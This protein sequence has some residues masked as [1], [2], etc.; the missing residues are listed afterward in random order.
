M[1]RRAAVALVLSGTVSA[2]SVLPASA[3]D[4]RCSAAPLDG[5]IYLR[6]GMN[7]WIPA[8]EYAFTWD[9][10]SYVLSV[11]LQGMQDFKIADG[12]WTPARSFGG[13]A[14]MP[15][16][17][18]DVLI[19]VRAAADGGA[20]NLSYRFDG[21]HTLRLS[22]ADG[23]PR[24]HVG[25]KSWTDRTAPAVTDPVALSLRHDSRDIAHKAPFGAVPTGTEVRFALDALPGVARATLVLETRT[26]EGN[27]EVL[28]YQDA[29]RIPMSRTGAGADGTE[30]WTAAHRFDAIGVHGYWFEVESGGQVFAYQNN[31]APIYWTRERGAN[32]LGAVGV[33][34]SD[35][36]TI[37]RFRL[38]VHRP[39]FTVPGW[40]RD[41]VYYYIF[42]ERFRNGDPS[43]DP[44]RGVT[45][46]QDKEVE[47]H[48]DWTGRPF[49]PGS[50]DGSDE[51][52]NN[53]FFGGDLAG[54]IEKLD[55]IADLGANTLYMTPIF[56]AASN[57]KYDTADY[58]N[59]D[60]HFGSNADF[61]RLTREAARRGIR[62]IVDVSLNHTGRDSVYFDRYGKL[63]GVGALEKGEVRPDSPYADWYRL[64]PAAS[65]P[66]DRYVG[67]TGAKDLPE[68]NEASP[69][70]RRFAYGTPGSVMQQWL[71]R[72]AAGWRMDVAPWVPDDFW[73][74]W[75]RAVKGHNPD[76]LTIA[77]TW[78]DS[79]KYFLGDSFDTTMNYIFRNAVLDFAGGGNAAANYRNVELMRELYPPQSFF[80]LMNLLSTH[81]AARSLHVLGDHGDDPQATAAAKR[82]YR[83]ALFFQMTFPGAPAIFYGDE[84]GLSGGDD[85]DNR[86]PYPWADKGGMP[87][88][89]ML[90]MVKRLIRLRND[91]PILRH[92]SLGAP[93]H[94][95][96][97]VIVVPRR[98]GA[99]VAIVAMNNA[100]TPR[101]VRVTLPADWPATGTF[102]DAVSGT[103]V[104]TDGGNVSLT[105]P[106]LDGLVLLS[107]PAGRG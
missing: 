8:A 85:P 95:D 104:P 63:P 54:I 84:V 55:H 64:N 33:L 57:H 88:L 94:T 106:P 5:P 46:Y 35:P 101:T 68:L 19:P 48:A 99:T 31:T 34:P 60:P 6:G 11:E 70:F 76:A 28:S 96:G 61:E 105:I 10:D 23:T 82:R 69:A 9:C 91:T 16:R 102:T 83:L 87:D 32:G 73:R 30:R 13:T 89:A 37:R 58:E 107:T 43:N 77:E 86:R 52:A 56:T 53:D 93:L 50:G 42:P 75:R 21:D 51:V 66:E 41:A 74:E 25:P 59:V 3:A 103:T 98:D 38:T 90:D 49:R 36:A 71:D 62:V 17:T 39:D 26:L 1:L 22:F 15:P 40:A 100:D 2:L 44:R 78:F 67:W 80:A 24:L 79:S 45:T 47:I 81:D 65:D 27:Q 4:R 18:G 92:G 7:G 72:G 20:R 97:S 14:D 12:A 29:L